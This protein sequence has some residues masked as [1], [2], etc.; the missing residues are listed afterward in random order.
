MV[1]GCYRNFTHERSLQQNHKNRC[2]ELW[3]TQAGESWKILI[4]EEI[5]IGESRKIPTNELRKINAGELRTT[6]PCE[7]PNCKQNK[8]RPL[9]MEDSRPYCLKFV[10]FPF[11]LKSDD[12]LR[13]CR[14]Q[15]WWAVKNI[16][17]SKYI[18]MESDKCK[19]DTYGVFQPLKCE[20]P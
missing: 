3:K 17:N 15:K 5:P 18:N 1:K 2:G 8:Q 9:K 10:H 4:G 14:K 11:A 12:L 16:H 20:K 7:S 19:L 13:C 6:D